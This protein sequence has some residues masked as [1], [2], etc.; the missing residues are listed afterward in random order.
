MPPAVSAFRLGLQAEQSVRCFTACLGGV[1]AKI[2]DTFLG[3]Y[4]FIMESIMG[5][6]YVWK[7]HISQYAT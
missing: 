7:S 3:V 6:P 5:S 4:L 2:R 1:L